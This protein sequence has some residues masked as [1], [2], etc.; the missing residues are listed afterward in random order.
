M[1]DLDQGPAIGARVRPT[2]PDELW[3]WLREHVGV[4][5]ARVP[6]NPG[7]ATPFDYVCHAYF[8]TSAP[9]DCVVWANRGGGKTFLGAIATMLDLVFKGGIEVRIL[10]GS[11]Q[12]AK[13]MHAH[14][15]W[16]FAKPVLAPLVDGRITE[17]RLR[18]TNGSSVELLAQSQT[19][20]RG[21]RVQKL[22]CDEV[23]LFDPEVWEA[24][25]LTTR[26]MEIELDDGSTMRVRGAIECLSTMHRPFGLMFNLVK[27]AS[28]GGRKLFKWG[29]LDVLER[30]GDEY[31]CGTRDGVRLPVVEGDEVSCEGVEDACALLVECR[32]RAKGIERVGHIP[33]ADAL[34][35][36]SRVGMATWESEMLCLRPSRE[37]T[38]LPEFDRKRHVVSDVPESVLR[39]GVWVGGMDFGFRA[40]TVILWAVL[41]GSDADVRRRALWIVDERV[42]SGVIVSEHVRAI[43]ASRWPDLEW[44]GVDPAGRQRSEQTGISASE[45]LSRAGL[46]VRDRRLPLGEGVG[47]LRARLAPAVGSARL[48][49]HERCATLIESMERYHYP[50]DERATHPVKDGADHAVDALRYLVQNIDKAYRTVVRGY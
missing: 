45:V 32:G 26:S 27:Q 13:R 46:T 24:A 34:D 28:G 10:A 25:Q 31:A 41:V 16:L 35:Q 17:S 42:K 19:A 36:R 11:L 40:P 44:I 9:A 43:E 3:V 30:C 8:E 48:Y 4:T 6:M 18:L 50:E 33:I 39:E 14:L 12:Q 21:T 7:H 20:V 37:D 47:L 5:L 22:R 2:S 49:V 29:V 15:R 23:E 38:V 1:D